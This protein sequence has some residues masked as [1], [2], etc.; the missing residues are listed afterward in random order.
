MEPNTKD[1]SGGKLAV[2]D[3]A[4]EKLH[5]YWVLFHE[6]FSSTFHWKQFTTLIYY[7]R[8]SVL[9]SGSSYLSN[10]HFKTQGLQPVHK[11]HSDFFY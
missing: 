6:A 5:Q 7:F 10:R 2:A 4:P 3:F 8:I 11:H 9:A 1:P